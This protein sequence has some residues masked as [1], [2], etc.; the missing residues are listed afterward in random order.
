ADRFRRRAADERKCPASALESLRRSCGAGRALCGAYAAQEPGVHRG[1][2][3]H[4]RAGHWY[5]HG[6][7]QPDR[8][9]TLPRLARQSSRRAGIAAVAR[10]AP[11]EDD[12]PQQLWLLLL[13]FRGESHELLFFSTVLQCDAFARFVFT[14]GGFCARATAESERQR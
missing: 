13:P 3:A 8:R 7:F 5:E 9:R 12:Q 10:S 11:A 2:R 14:R 4:T 6:Y 1:Y